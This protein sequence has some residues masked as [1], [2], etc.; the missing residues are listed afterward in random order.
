MVRRVLNLGHR[1]AS[2]DAPQNTLAAFR[3]ANAYGADGYE[4][5]AQ[6]SKDGALVVIH[7][8]TVDKTTDGSGRVSSFTLDELKRLDA[9]SK[10]CPEF[11]GERI[12]T[13]AE[14]FDVRQAHTIVNI[15]LK[16][17][18]PRDSGLEDATIRL[19]RERKLEDRV[20]VSSFNPFSLLRV[21]R[22]APELRIGLLYAPDLP[23]YLRR[24]WFRFVLRPDA[25][26]PRYQMVN[27]R[28]MEWAQK[29]GCDVNV[30]TVDDP[31]DMKR[32]AGL[33]VNAIITNRPDVA[34]DALVGG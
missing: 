5:D 31:E 24:A 1:G 8:F 11:A 14:V 2:H 7:D 15:E 3:L 9:G 28:Y 30:W 19:V 33:G 29:R 34:R 16:T 4:L 32:L 27:A 13:L 17:A 22:R 26:H 21:R 6:L 25:L 18:S 10:F 12:P 23:L 20:I